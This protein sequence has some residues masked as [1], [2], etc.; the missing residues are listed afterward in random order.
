MASTGTTAFP[1]VPAILAE[2]GGAILGAVILAPLLYYA[3]GF[4]MIGSDLG[5]GVLALQ[6]YAAILGA[7]VGAGVGVALVG[8]LMRQGGSIWLAILLAV[9]GGSL[10]AILPRVVPGIR[11]GLFETLFAALGVIVVMAVVGYNLRRRV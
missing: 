4:A 2:F 5:M 1:S 3:I 10:T 6:I 8:R 7:T 11:L 9:L